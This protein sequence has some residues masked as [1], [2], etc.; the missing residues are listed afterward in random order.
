MY[1]AQSKHDYGIREYYSCRSFLISASFAFSVLYSK[2]QYYQTI[3]SYLYSTITLNNF[4]CSLLSLKEKYEIVT[5]AYT[6]PFLLFSLQHWRFITVYLVTFST[7]VKHHF[8]GRGGQHA[9]S[10]TSLCFINH[11]PLR[12]LSVSHT[13]LQLIRPLRHSTLG[14]CTG[15]RYIFS[16]LYFQLVDVIHAADSSTT[17]SSL[18]N[19]ACGSLI[20][21]PELYF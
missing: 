17:I 18:G 20:L 2:S 14:D 4:F 9:P 13:Q 5:P 12:L 15:K 3:I 21:C 1:F 10:C 6:Y 16:T 11:N 19:V 7:P 8:W